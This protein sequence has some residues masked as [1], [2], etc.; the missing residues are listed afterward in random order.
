MAS[1]FD[2]YKATSTK[3]VKKL[4]E[5]EDEK[6]LTK[7]A[8]RIDIAIG[9][10]KIRFG[11]KHPGEDT[12]M[13]MRGCHW[14]KVSKEGSDEAAI[15]T[16]PD[17]KLHGD[18]SM[19]PCEAYI[20][21]CKERLSTGKASDSDKLKKITAW[22]GGMGLSCTWLSY[23]KKISKTER[24]G[25]LIYEYWRNI[26]DDLKN[27]MVTEDEDE[28]IELD[29]FTDPLKGKCAIIT[30]K[31]VGKK[32][33][34]T[35]KISE[36]ITK[37][38]EE[39]MVAYDKLTPISNMPEFHYTMQDFETAL[40]GI[41]YWDEAESIGLFDDEEFVE[42]LA[43]I[44]AELKAKLQG[45]TA[46]DEEGEEGDEDEPFEEDEAPK[47][48]KSSKSATPVA[49]KAGK[50]KKVVEEEPEEDQEEGEESEEATDEDD[51]FS[52]MDRRALIAYK[53]KQG[54]EEVKIYKTDDD[55]KIREKLR[56][57]AA[58]E[59]GDE[60]AE[61]EEEEAPVK[62]TT[63]K[64]VVAGTKPTTGKLSL[65]TIKAQLNSK[66]GKK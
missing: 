49:A 1:I 15:R 38:T 28:A 32:N 39:E 59:G 44:K 33:Q 5:E 14:L 46:D 35:M 19:D 65:E 29:P 53:A 55:D 48:K 51:E 54:W 22:K 40:E 4:T 6:T 30:V 56:E 16:V 8:G 23:A 3:V 21:L 7:R 45:V 25:W 61:V 63:K 9:E 42:T 36:N 27:Q 47:S 18:L 52:G 41:E 20:E 26:R 57:R 62:P 10:N 2:K 50:G 31:K 11:P 13:H 64:T 17:A 12:F 60:E 58:L 66:T 37:L 43:S 34:T 24:T